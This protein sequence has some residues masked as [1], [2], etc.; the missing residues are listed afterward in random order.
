MAPGNYHSKMSKTN[1][2]EQI[3][4]FTK[5]YNPKSGKYF[6]VDGLHWKHPKGESEL[7]R[8][9]LLNLA[10]KTRQ[11]RPAAEIYSLIESGA[12][13]HWVPIEI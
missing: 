3:C 13:Q 11:W 4:L 6:I 9:A 10:D 7:E 2:R 5:L 12:L 1:Q 8:V